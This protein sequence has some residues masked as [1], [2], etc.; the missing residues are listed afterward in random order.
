MLVLCSVLVAGLVPFQRPR[1]EVT[2]LPNENGLHLGKYGTIWSSNSFPP[3]TQEQEAS[4][5]LEMWLRPDVAN[6]SSTILAFYTPE[7]PL[8]LT[9]HQYHT[10]LIL[11]RK[12]HDDVR[13]T[14]VIGIKDA[15][16]PAKAAFISITSGSQKTIIYVNGAPIRSFPAFHM[17]NDCAGRLIIGTSPEVDN[18][19]AGDLRGLAIYRRELTAAEV[20]QDFEAWSARGGPQISGDKNP[21]ALYL[22]DEHGGSIIHDA[23]NRGINLSIPDRFSL[24][25]EQFLKPF[26]EEFKPTRSYLEDVLVNIGGF[27]PLG[28]IFFAY[29]SAVRPIKHPVLA[30]VFLGLGVSLTIEVLQSFLPTRDSGTTD[31]I[32]NTLGTYLGVRFSASRAARAFF[33]NFIENTSRD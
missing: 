16:H 24:V 8:Q 6:A 23:A 14:E 2:W 4:C 19:W 30:S 3:P 17:G 31:L 15:L 1:N 13:Y 28:F 5:S 25:H 20:L 18:S 32:T 7:N 9:V 21:L 33:K 10:L 11:Q 29:W 12:V 22:F 26:W 27:I